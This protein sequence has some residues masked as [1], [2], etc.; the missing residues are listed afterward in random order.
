MFSIIISRIISHNC[1]VILSQTST[2]STNQFIYGNNLK[3]GSTWAGIDQIEVHM[4]S[5]IED[6]DTF[7]AGVSCDTLMHAVELN[8]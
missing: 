2:R 3:F 6:I 1:Q 8:V 4:A 5:I 7:I